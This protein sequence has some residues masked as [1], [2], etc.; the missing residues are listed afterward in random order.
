MLF[1]DPCKNIELARFIYIRSL[2]ALWHSP[3][4]GG[5]RLPLWR[6]F[7]RHSCASALYVKTLL[8]IK[9][10][11]QKME[12]YITMRFLFCARIRWLAQK[13][14]VKCHKKPKRNAT[15]SKSKLPQKAKTICH[16]KQK[17]FGSFIYFIYLCTQN[18]MII[19]YGVLWDI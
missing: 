13:A 2:R 6:H 16:K 10:M 8:I 4:E 7:C 14:K 3:P 15:K 11:I 18:S 1:Y 12:Y 9:L 17:L 19:K 5:S